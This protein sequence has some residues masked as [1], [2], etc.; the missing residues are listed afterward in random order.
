MNVDELLKQMETSLEGTNEGIVKILEQ[1]NDHP[2]FIQQLLADGDK[3]LE[4]VSLLDLKNRSMLSYIH[5]VVLVILS[6]VERIKKGKVEEVEGLRQEAIE[7][8]ITQRVTLDKGIKPLE[9]KL[10][11]QLD[12]MVRSYN[13][14]Q[15]DYNNKEEES[16][17]AD[18][19]KQKESRG[20]DSEESSE[21]SSEDELSYRPDAS[22]LIKKPMKKTSKSTEAS[23]PSDP[24]ETYKPPKISAMAPPSSISNG[25]REN[26]RP[27]QKLQSMEEYLRES[28]DL[29]ME[30]RS[31]GANI[32]NHGRSVK[33]S[34]ERKREQEVQ[35]YEEENFTR[36]P[37]TMTKKDK[38]QKR[39]DM[40]NTF[41]GEDWSMFN[42]TRDIGE[43]TSRKRKNTSAW[44]KAKR[45][46]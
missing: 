39:R 28:S 12:K 38:S 4:D 25:Q 44:D 45:K 16:N 34:Q 20:S 7:N 26:N 3:K 37:N 6:Q 33:T 19:D 13:K 18:D 24:S 29:P 9:K 36:L 5:N 10:T 42:N 1:G 32:V 11:Y 21:E 2:E 8:A 15:S 31:I 40:V 43:G 35:R 14:M 27:N 41:G 46:R 22:S 23:D 17:V 30:D